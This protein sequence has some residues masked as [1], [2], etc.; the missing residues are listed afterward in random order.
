MK[1]DRIKPNIP[2]EAGDSFARFSIMPMHNKHF[3]SQ[4][5]LQLW[6][7]IS[8]IQYI[9]FVIS[10]KGNYNLSNNSLD[11][12]ENFAAGVKICEPKVRHKFGILSKAHDKQQSQAK[13]LFV[14]VWP[15]KTSASDHAALR[16]CALFKKTIKV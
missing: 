6:T 4:R 2:K 13:G 11:T 5:H 7:H 15:R 14:I 9:F 16:F 10:G 3:I 1:Y 8:K 12:R